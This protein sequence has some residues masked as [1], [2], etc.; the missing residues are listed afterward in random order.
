MG[1]RSQFT[2]EEAAAA[3]A[4]QANGNQTALG[5]ALRDLSLGSDASRSPA[6]RWA[7]RALRLAV[8]HARW[9][10]Y[11]EAVREPALRSYE[12]HP[13]G[14]AD[15]AAIDER[16][17]HQFHASAARWLPEGDPGWSA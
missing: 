9:S 15:L 8:A 4:S 1:L 14:G 10:A 13:A 17:R 5:R 7:A 2:L 3:L 16:R 11:D 6:V 12:A